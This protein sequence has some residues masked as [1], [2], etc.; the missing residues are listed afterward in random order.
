MGD[1]RSFAS[2]T[3]FTSQNRLEA[4]LLHSRHNFIFKLPFKYLMMRYMAI[5]C[6]GPAFNM[7]WLTIFTANAKSTLIFTITYMRD[8]TP[9]FYG[10]PLVFVC[11]FPISSS[12]IFN[13]FK[14]SSNGVWIHLYSSMLK[15]LR[16]SSM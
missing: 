15:C 4:V 10:T 2:P 1:R 16:I 5:Q 8:H 14:S 12:K 11:T 9:A 3:Q 7:N 6:G 13:N